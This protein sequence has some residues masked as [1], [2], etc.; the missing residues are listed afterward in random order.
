MAKPDLVEA[1]IAVHKEKLTSSE[2]DPLKAFKD[3]VVC[4]GTYD[5][6]RCAVYS[7]VEALT[8]ALH[9]GNEIQRQTLQSLSSVV[10]DH[11]VAYATPMNIDVK[12]REIARIRARGG[13]DEIC[14][15]L[16]AGVHVDCISAMTWQLAHLEAIKR[17]LDLN[18]KALHDTSTTRHKF[19][20]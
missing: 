10:F 8:P 6:A 7:M 9:E 1:A 20:S 4:K 17:V 5:G 16:L 11:H 18:D 2:S 14:D 12:L 15:A 3:F 13:A 19:M